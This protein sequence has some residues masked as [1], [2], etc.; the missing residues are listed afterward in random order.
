MEQAGLPLTANAVAAFALKESFMGCDPDAHP[1]AA[2]P[3]VRWAYQ[4]A[5]DLD[6]CFQLE[7][8]SAFSELKRMFPERFSPVTH[9][10]VVGGDHF[11]SAALTMA[12]YMVFAAAMMRMHVPDSAAWMRQHPD[13]QAGAKALAIVYNRGAWSEGIRVALQDC[14]DSPELVGCVQGP[15]GCQPGA[16]DVCDYMRAIGALSAA[17]SRDGLLYDE[18]VTADAVGAYVD[19]IAPLFPEADIVRARGDAVRAWTLYAVAQAA[20]GFQ[21]VAQPV[22]DA[23]VAALPT[24]A[25]PA[26]QVSCCFGV[27]CPPDVPCG[28]AFQCVPPMA[29]DA[30]P[31]CD[32]RQ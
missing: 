5:A 28:A 19:S 26:Q 17:A 30:A 16:T 7:C 27:S 23:I 32:E 1:N 10:E 18:P 22:L 6:G 20:P 25:D 15:I 3:S 29:C 31:A 13:K 21:Q 12:H 24:A 4:P 9:A 2:D 11:E 8:G 14:S